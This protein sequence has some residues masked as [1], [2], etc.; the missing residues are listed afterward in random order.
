MYQ[1]FEWWEALLSPLV[2]EDWFFNVVS[3][4]GSAILERVSYSKFLLVRSVT[5]FEGLAFYTSWV[6]LLLE[7]VTV[8]YVQ[9]A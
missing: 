7:D 8:E 6:H 3:D 5:I 4:S 9:N 1:A 2:P